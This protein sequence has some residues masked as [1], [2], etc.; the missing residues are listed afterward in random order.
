MLRDDT[1]IETYLQRSLYKISW[2]LFVPRSFLANKNLILYSV[3]SLLLLNCKLPPRCWF[4]NCLLNYQENLKF[5][6]IAN[7]TSPQ[8][9][10][11]LP[12]HGMSHE[13]SFHLLSEEQTN[14]HQ[15]HSYGTFW[16]AICELPFYS[17][18]TGHLLFSGLFFYDICWMASFWLVL[19]QNDIFA[20]SL[21]FDSDG[22]SQLFDDF[23]RVYFDKPVLYLDTCLD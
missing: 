11:T 22:G 6:Y 8:D 18:Y 15:W 9:I 3:L 12:Q 13:N 4:S 14:F 19:C 1:N 23:W 2:Q 5:P 21:E 10:Q 7:K 20:L 17:Y 16:H